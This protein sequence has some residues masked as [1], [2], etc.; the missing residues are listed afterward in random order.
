MEQNISADKAANAIAPLY[1]AL[2]DIVITEA[3]S[4]DIAAGSPQ[5]LILTAPAGWSF[6]TSTGAVNVGLSV[7]V[8]NA[9]IALTANTITITFDVSGTAGLDEITISGIEIQALNGSIL[10]NAGQIYRSTA[11]AGTAVIASLISSSNGD[12]SG[13]T[14]F[15]SLSQVVGTVAQLAYTIQPGAATV[16]AVFGQQPVVVTQDQFG[17]LSTTGLVAT[18]NVVI[19]LSAGSGL[20]TGTTSLN[21]GTGGGNGTVSFTNL[22]IDAAGVKQ[23]TAASAPLTSSVTNN[24]TVAAASSTTV[25]TSDINPSC[26]SANVNLTATVTPSI[27][28]LEP[29]SFLMA[30]LLWEP[31]RLLLA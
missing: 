15:G 28:N 11:N 7:D 6:N 21:I 14:D 25:L 20:L 12:G 19:N 13:G 22:Q 2:G 31:Q 1:T 30:L 5:T 8:S 3:S 17:T 9:S 26:V 18:Q 29:L 23:L 27:A 10:P 24:F 16:G 4:N